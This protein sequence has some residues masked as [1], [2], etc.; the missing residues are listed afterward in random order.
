MPLTLDTRRLPRVDRIEAAAAFLEDTDVPSALA[1]DKA[2]DLGHRFTGWQLAGGV[3]VLDVQG[4]GM[5]V[6][7]NARHMRVSAPERLCLAFQ[8]Q[9]QGVSDHR[10]LTTATAR[11]HLNLV[12][13]TAESDY[14]WTGQVERRVVLFDY[15]ALDLSVD[16]VRSA[17]G[18]LDASPLYD[19]VRA[20]VR[21]LDPSHEALRTTAPGFSLTAGSLELVR[22][23]ITT[24]A[25]PDLPSEADS[26]DILR[27]RI[28]SHIEERVLDPGLSARSIAQAHHI[29]VRHL[30]AVWSGWPLSLREHIIRGRLEHARRQLAAHPA[31]PVTAIAHRCGFSSAAHFTRRFHDAYGLPPSAWR[32]QFTEAEGPAR[33]PDPGASALRRRPAASLT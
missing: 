10:G 27:T 8:L 29:S 18:Q 9:G 15:A 5:R 23:L 21:S 7:R 31:V 17:V 12:D 13:G 22:A 6:T 11:G 19:L 3:Q 24:A 28:L 4:S 32:E 30:Y 33:R 14:A 20:H 26:H 25:A 16:L 1:F 2:Q